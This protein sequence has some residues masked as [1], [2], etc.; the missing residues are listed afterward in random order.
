[1]NKIYSIV[2]LQRKSAERRSDSIAEM[3]SRT[4]GLRTETFFWA[5]FQTCQ[6]NPRDRYSSVI[7][8]VDIWFT[9]DP[10]LIIFWRRW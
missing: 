5:S 6:S 1:M 10:L 4:V 7:G 3:I 9:L 8:T 2:I